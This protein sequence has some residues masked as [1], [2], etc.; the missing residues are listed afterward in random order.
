M[1]RSAPVPGFLLPNIDL[2]S[3][4]LREPR[5]A[6]KLVGLK[7]SNRRTPSSEQ[8]AAAVR[9]LN[10]VRAPLFVELAELLKDPTYGKGEPAHIAC[11]R[12]RNQMRISPLEAEAIAEALRTR[13][14]L[15]RH[16]PA[17]RRRLRE[18][19]ATLR[20]STARQSFTCPLLDG[21]LCL[22]HHAA[23][24]IGCLA[25]NPGRDYSDAGWFAFESRD[26]ANDR[27]WGSRWPLR[28]I[29]LALARVLGEEL[30][31]A[32]RPGSAVRRRREAPVRSGLPGAALLREGA[33]RGRP[34]GGS[35][36]ARRGT[37]RGR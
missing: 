23:K 14:D 3:L 9:A 30:P 4:I 6:V 22:V 27:L 18:E 20:D 12:A 37:S 28:A 29:P 15:R 34:R 24:P 32:G 1:I 25:W 7:R 10:G 31:A 5:R 11:T 17:I 8:L 35:A 33:R 36:G 21:K 16:L 13:L 2:C 19:L 26:R